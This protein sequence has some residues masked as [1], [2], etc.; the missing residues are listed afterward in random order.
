MR[1]ARVLSRVVGEIEVFRI[2]LYVDGG[3]HPRVENR[4]LQRSA[5]EKRAD[6]G[7]LGG[8]PAADTV[9]I[10]QAADSMLVTES[11][12]NGRRVLSLVGGV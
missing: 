7:K 12:L 1:C 11:H 6:V 4:V 3:G 8:Q 10:F 5:L 2:D 9:H